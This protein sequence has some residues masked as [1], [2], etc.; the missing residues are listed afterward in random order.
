MGNELLSLSLSHN[1]FFNLLLALL[2]VHLKSLL[3]SRIIQAPITADA[4][5]PLK[6]RQIGFACP[7]LWGLTLQLSFLFL[8]L[9]HLLLSLPS[10]SV[11]RAF[12]EEDC[13]L[14]W[15]FFFEGLRSGSCANDF[16]NKTPR[17]PPLEGVLNWTL[18]TKNILPSKFNSLNIDSALNSCHYT[19]LS[20]AL[21]ANWLQDWFNHIWELHSECIIYISNLKVFN[22]LIAIISWSIFNS[23]IY[24]MA[25]FLFWTVQSNLTKRNRN[26]TIKAFLICVLVTWTFHLKFAFHKFPMFFYASFLTHKPVYAL[27]FSRSL[28]FSFPKLTV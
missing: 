27:K 24:Q 17:V 21:L 8:C 25:N 14:V 15:S 2:C 6:A 3:I 13:C 28:S 26:R 11:L 23:H 10:R 5:C 7:R 20:Q 16:A 1:L 4:Y 18:Q 22:L 19:V 9:A 12:L